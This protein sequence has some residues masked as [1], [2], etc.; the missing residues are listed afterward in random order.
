VDHFV[1]HPLGLQLAWDLYEVKHS[2]AAKEIQKI[3]PLISPGRLRRPITELIT[4][5]PEYQ[6]IVRMIIVRKYDKAHI[7]PAP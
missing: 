1:G 3:N 7:F 4:V 6:P 5:S 2:S